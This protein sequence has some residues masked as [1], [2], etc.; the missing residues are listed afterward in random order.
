VRGPL[1]NQASALKRLQTLMA[2]LPE[3]EV[4]LGTTP[5]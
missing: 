3:I 4:E 2:D 5:A 1:K